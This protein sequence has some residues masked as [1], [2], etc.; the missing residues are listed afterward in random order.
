MTGLVR[1]RARPVD[2]HTTLP[3]VI[4]RDAAARGPAHGVAALA[5]RARRVPLLRR[6]ARR[7]GVA[8]GRVTVVQ[9]ELYAHGHVGYGEAKPLHRY[10]ESIA[11]ALAFLERAKV[12]LAGLSPDELRAGALDDLPGGELAARAALDAAAHD[13]AGKLDGQPV[14]RLLGLAPGGPPTS[15]TVPLADPD[16]MAQ[17]AERAARR[18]TVVKL[19]LGGR[20]GLDAERVRA[21][22]RATNVPLR[23]DAN[24]AWEADEALDLLHAIVPLGIELVEQPLRAG[25]PAGERLKGASPVPVFVDEDCRTEADVAACARRAHGVNV[26]LSKCGGLRAALRCVAAARTLG[27]RTMIG[28]MIESSLGIAAAVQIAAAFDLA[29]LDANLLLD[30]DPFTGLEIADGAQRPS[31]RPGLGVAPVRAR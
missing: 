11:S 14:W 27:L 20:D 9:V 12:P 17:A 29:D 7:L 26:K 28:C 25:D 2:V 3:F 15:L 18:F 16:A 4:A 23:V 10:G 19:K 1:L 5:E 31:S 30:D 6:A 22:R 21:V 24:E 13:L 8:A